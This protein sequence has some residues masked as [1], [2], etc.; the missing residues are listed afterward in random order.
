[1]Y[2]NQ[3]SVGSVIIGL[4]SA[5]AELIGNIDKAIRNHLEILMILR[6]AFFINTLLRNKR[7]FA[8]SLY[9]CS[10]RVQVQAVLHSK[11]TAWKYHM[12][13]GSL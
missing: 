1:V 6:K 7:L 13:G 9:T 2:E 11:H 10:G 3:K 4:A 5:F 12:W 8:H